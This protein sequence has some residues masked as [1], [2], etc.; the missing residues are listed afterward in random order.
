MP[1]WWSMECAQQPNLIAQKFS[2]QSMLRKLRFLLLA[3]LCLVFTASAQHQE[4]DED[5]EIWK[6]REKPGLDTNSFLHAFK[7]GTISGHLRYFFMAT[8]NE[9]GLS[10]FFANAAGGGL[11][12][13]TAK[14]KGFQMG[15]SGFFT[16]NVG[17]SDFLKRDQRTGQV[18]RYEIGLF[19]VEDPLN[20]KDIDRLEE[21]YFKYSYKKLSITAGKQLIN[22]PFINLQDG[23]MRPTEVNGLW[24][25]HKFK[26][27]RIEAGYIDQ[28][29]PRGTVKWFK[30]ENSFGI[31]SSG[32]NK[33]GS[34][35]EYE[36]NTHTKGLAILGITHKPNKY[37]SIQFWNIYTEN[38]FN[39][40]FVQAELEKEAGHKQ[41]W[42]AGIQLFQQNR[43]GEGG[44]E[45]LKKKYMQD[46][47]SLVLS[48]KLGWEKNNWKTSFNFT[49]IT[50]QGRY[51]MPREWGRDPFYTFMPRER[52]EGLANVYAYV[53]KMGKSFPKQRV[54]A[55]LAVGH[56]NLPS[57]YDYASNKYGLPSYNQLNIDL[58]Y[59]FNGILTGLESQLLFVYKGKSSN[60]TIDDKYV[61]NKVNMSLW[62]IVLN[63]NF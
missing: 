1:Q 21:L 4:I 38:I 25:D 2:N 28:I 5:P 59:T 32:V 56:F 51:T 46:K 18:S 26:K 61:I 11:K 31:Y 47:S 9:K 36:T 40:S 35:S 43:I 39:A 13:E 33:D 63:Y 15:I 37:I 54:S 53:L 12:F 23:R 6:A 42:I 44:N 7:Q 52:N 17:S 60:E 57:V 19:D 45:E 41:K 30:V 22:T 48:T 58:R 50:N 8:D 24:L 27:T 62:N 29:S 10:D 49:H 3:L 20:K 14:F 16:F 34:K 55:N